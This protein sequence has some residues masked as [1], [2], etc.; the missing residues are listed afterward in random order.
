MESD[1]GG[2]GRLLDEVLEDLP[3]RNVELISA[4][5]MVPANVHQSDKAPL[6]ATCLGRRACKICA[7]ELLIILSRATS[8]QLVL[9]TDVL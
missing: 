6:P 8:R 1:I 5:D 4:S 9:S 7:V 2:I 3:R